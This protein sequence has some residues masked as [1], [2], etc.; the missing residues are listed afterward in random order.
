[1]VKETR[2]I[3][4]LSDI[5]AI[6]LWCQHCKREAVQ[7]VLATDVP[8][9]CPFCRKD[10]EPDY[11]GSVRGDNFQIMKAMQRLLKAQSESPDMIIRL[12][13]TGKRTSSL[14]EAEKPKRPQVTTW[15]IT[16]KV[17]Q[18]FIAIQGSLQITECPT[19]VVVRS[20]QNGLDS[21]VEQVLYRIL[22][23]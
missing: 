12:R 17:V 1:M 13:S 5:K 10:W 21:L 4:D 3:F 15:N 19:R 23:P 18:S 6:R 9:Q 2:Q 11:P 16:S 20:G 22:P 7:S 14:P 8:K